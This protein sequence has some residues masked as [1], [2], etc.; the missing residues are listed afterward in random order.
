[1]SLDEPKVGVSCG[2]GRVARIEVWGGTA[3]LSGC[4]R[5]RYELTRRWDEPFSGRPN[6]G[7]VMLNPST[8]DAEKDD[9]TIRRVIR[10]SR[11]LGFGGCTVVNL[12]ALR[13]TDP[14]ELMA[15]DDPVGPMNDLIAGF[16]IRHLS[17]VIAA[18][19]AHKLARDREAWFFKQV[20]QAGTEVRCL[21]VTKNGYPRHP[22]YVRKDALATPYHPRAHAEARP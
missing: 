4:D 12:Y 19:G 5:Y 10:F 22:L 17:L 1:M 21:G 9:P 6:L 2:G 18:W 7:W 15:A 13:A 3:T 11:V 20:R 14:R 8:A 16:W